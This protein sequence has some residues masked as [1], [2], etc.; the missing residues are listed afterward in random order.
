[1]IRVDLSVEK[2]ITFARLNDGQE[3]ALARA[4][5]RTTI[6]DLSSISQRLQR[7]ALEYLHSRCFIGDCDSAGYPPA[8]L[9]TLLESVGKS[10]AERK[11]LCSEVLTILANEWE[12]ET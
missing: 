2:P 10:R 4:V 9:D 11:A 1:M 8:L 6:R 5:I 7:D 3:K 12:C